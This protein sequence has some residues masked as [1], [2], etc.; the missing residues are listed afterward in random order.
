MERDTLL[1]TPPKAPG[2]H[3]KA[4]E[5]DQAIDHLIKQ[6]LDPGSMPRP[7]AYN[8]VKRAAAELGFNTGIG[9]SDPVI[10]GMTSGSSTFM[11]PLRP[12]RRCRG[13][14]PPI[15]SAPSLP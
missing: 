2:R 15:G 12:P 9:F 4:P 5:I 11:T 14:Y 8:A 3:S 6:G 10:Q 7:Q 1:A 13:R